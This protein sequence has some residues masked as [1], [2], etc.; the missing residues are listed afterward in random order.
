ML[1]AYLFVYLL[2][3]TDPYHGLVYEDINM[4]QVDYGIMKHEDCDSRECEEE[5]VSWYRYNYELLGE[6]DEYAISN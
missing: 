2:V 1:K 3:I 4:Y 5:E 6:H